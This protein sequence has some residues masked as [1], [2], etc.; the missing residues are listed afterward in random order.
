[1]LKRTI[2]GFLLAAACLL[3]HTAHAAI[4]RC[5][6]ATGEALFTDRPCPSGMRTTDV[7]TDV[8]VCGS[9]DCL[10]RL[11]RDYQEAQERRRTEQEQLAILEEERRRRAEEDARLEALRSREA[12]V[13]EPVAPVESPEPAYP[14]VGVP[15]WTCV[16][17][18]CFPQH[19]PHRPGYPIVGK[20]WCVGARCFPAPYHS[21]RPGREYS[22]RR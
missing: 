22:E 14:I 7:T 3:A 13:P 1:V 8:Q 17:A 12:V 21:M 15:L 16:G 11:E 10:R 20:P 18:R 4:F 19:R 5:V 2:I 6:D 9:A